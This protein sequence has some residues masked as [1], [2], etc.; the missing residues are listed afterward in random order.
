MN[1]DL[2]ITIR[3]LDFKRLFKVVRSMKFIINAL[4]PRLGTNEL[5]IYLGCTDPDRYF[6]LGVE[7]QKVKNDTFIS[8]N[9]NQHLEEV[10]NICKRFKIKVL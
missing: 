1:D 2:F 8:P 6:K 10:L 9:V 3:V 5:E 7:F 4:R